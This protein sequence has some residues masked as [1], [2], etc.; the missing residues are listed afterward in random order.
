MKKLFLP[1][2]VPAALTVFCPAAF[3][4]DGYEIPTLQMVLLN[5]PVL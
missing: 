4:H 1:V 3:A 5:I 2:V